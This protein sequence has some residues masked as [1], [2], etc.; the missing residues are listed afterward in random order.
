MKIGINGYEAVVSRFG[1][2]EKTGLPNRVGSS[3]VCYQTLLNLAQIDKKNDY[4]IFLPVDPVSDLPKERENWKYNVFSSRNWTLF[5]LSKQLAASKLNVF[6]S[7]THYLP[8][9]IS[10]PS[11]ISILDVSY[12]YFPNLFKRKDLYQ[13]KFWGKYSIKKADKII[14]ISESSKSDII[15]AYR[16]KEDKISVVY[17]GIKQMVGISFMDKKELKN[18]FGIDKE[19]ILFVGTLQPRKN[20]ERLIEA[21]SKI[22]QKD[23]R[24]V[25]IG[26]KGWQFEKI[27]QAPQKFGVL[28]RVSFLQNI[29]DNDLPSFYKNALF[30]ILP[31]LYEGFGLPVLEA[32]QY[33]CPVI[34]SNVSSLPEVGGVAALYI[35]PENVDDIKEKMEK[36]AQDDKLREELIKKGKEQVKKFSWEKTASETLKVLEEVGGK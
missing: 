25:I 10:V 7:P 31:S 4:T 21:F 18:K 30:F 5:G 12:L 36:L 17:P 22:K 8:L 3:E 23:L 20:V 28:E 13:L 19:F 33:D 29:E 15:K 34:T 11:V 1:F 2:N 14:T 32:M 24:L 26:K 9:R 35:N 6:F 16:V 27:L